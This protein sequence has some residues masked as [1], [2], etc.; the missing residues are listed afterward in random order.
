[1]IRCIHKYEIWND[2]RF[3]I[4]DGIGTLFH[5]CCVHQFG[6]AEQWM[7]DIDRGHTKYREPSRLARFSTLTHLFSKTITVLSV[8]PTFPVHVLED[9]WKQC[10]IDILSHLNKNFSEERRAVMCRRFYVIMTNEDCR[11]TWRSGVS[12][13]RHKRTRLRLLMNAQSPCKSA[14]TRSRVGWVHLRTQ[15]DHAWTRRPGD[16]R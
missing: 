4:A 14:W 3:R 15:V 10:G 7:D 1:M 12:K 16:H 11:N 5:V 6:E 8:Q 13:G 9:L 2:F